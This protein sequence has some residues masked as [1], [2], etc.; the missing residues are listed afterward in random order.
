MNETQ[1]VATGDP[2]CYGVLSM[3]NRSLVY[4]DKNG[5]YL[6]GWFCSCVGSY[7]FVK[8]SVRGDLLSDCPSGR[9][10]QSRISRDIMSSSA[11][12]SA[13]WRVAGLSYLQYSNL[14]ATMLRDALK[15]PLKE[16]AKVR[17]IVYFKNVVYEKG[18]PVK[19]STSRFALP[20]P[21]L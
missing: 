17:E 18:Q 5:V 20:M 1:A 2:A 4:K 9:L 6:R 8:L 15:E 3:E 7:S 10:A 19:Q 21:W 14:C 12:A 13:Y 16:A 11:S